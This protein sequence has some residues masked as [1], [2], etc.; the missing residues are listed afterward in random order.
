MK[1]LQF[2]DPNDLLILTQKLPKCTEKDFEMI[3]DTEEIMYEECIQHN[4]IGLSANQLGILKRFFVIC[5]PKMKRL[6]INPIILEGR[7]SAFDKEGCLSFANGKKT[8]KKRFKMIDVSWID[9]DWNKNYECLS[10]KEAQVF[11][12]EMDHM[13]WLI[14]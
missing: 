14:I 9:L 5:T 7:W 4:W 12:H 3:R 13:N 1:I 8:P 10:W 2:T 6:F 11:Q